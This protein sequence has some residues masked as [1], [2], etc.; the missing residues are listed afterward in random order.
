M[1][2]ALLQLDANIKRWGWSSS[3]PLVGVLRLTPDA[4]VGL[5][6]DV[7]QLI[8]SEGRRAEGLG[9]NKV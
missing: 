1:V 2:Q 4:E 9:S 6:L 5:D 3:K 8:S 7:S